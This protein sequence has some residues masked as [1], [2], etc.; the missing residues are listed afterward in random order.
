MAIS[1]YQKQHRAKCGKVETRGEKQN[2]HQICICPDLAFAPALMQ[3]M[4]ESSDLEGTP[5]GHQITKTA[6]LQ[7]LAPQFCMLPCHFFQPL[8][9]FQQPLILQCQ[10]P[11]SLTSSKQVDAKSLFSCRQGFRHILILNCPY[12]STSPS[13]G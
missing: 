12:L 13:V 4:V 10:T 7:C 11:G 8:S 9:A 1:P 5:K 6:L 2:S 3:K